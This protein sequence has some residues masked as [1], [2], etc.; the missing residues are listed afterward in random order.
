MF[1]PKCGASQPESAMFC[2]KCGHQFTNRPPA[3][4][5]SATVKGRHDVAKKT[6]SFTPVGVIARVASAAT[7]AFMLMPWVEVPALKSLGQLAGGFGISLP[8]DDSFPMYDMGGLTDVLDFITQSS[9]F[10]AIQ[11]GFFAFWVLAL[12]IIAIGLVRSFFGE[13]PMGMLAIGGIAAAF[14]AVV[15]FAAIMYL[16]GA[17]SAQFAQLIGGSAQMFVVPF[18]VWGTVIA[19]ITSTVCSRVRQ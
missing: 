11:K 4:A 14:V 1:C 17:Q 10:G 18:A 2:A 6:G 12:L 7:A 15:W 3:V 8:T 9:A 5:K 16:D 19:G 13:K